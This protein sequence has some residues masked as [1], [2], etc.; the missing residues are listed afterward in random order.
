MSKSNGKN[1]KLLFIIIGVVLAVAIAAGIIF[2]S[3]MGN[4]KTPGKKN[5][6][7][8]NKTPESIELIEEGETVK[9]EDVTAITG[10]TSPDGT[11]VDKEGII[12]QKGHRI[13][14]TGQ[15]DAS[16]NL[17]YTTGKVNSKGQ[18]LYTKNV[19]NSFGELIYY[20]GSYNSDGKLLLKPTSDKPDYTTN[21]RP[22]AVSPTQPS[23]SVT[24]PVTVGNTAK[25]TDSKREAMAFFGGS[26]MDM[27]NSVTSCK[28]GGFVA[29]GYS[30]SYNGSLEGV[31][32]NWAGHGMVVKYDTNGNVLWKYVV[33]GDSEVSFNGV[34]EL[35]DGTIVAVGYTMSETEEPAR[36]SK[37]HSGLIVR[38]KKSGELMWTYVF[39]GG[40]SSSGEFISCVDATPDGGFVVGGKAISS[41]GFFKSDKSG[42][43][44][45]IIKFDK[46]CN[47]KW[48]RVLT[49]SMSN[50]FSAISVN[51][52]GDIYATCETVSTDGDFAGFTYSSELTKNTV[53][54]K[55]NKNGDLE[56][57][58]YLESTG[59]SEYN[60][61]FATEDGGC[62]VGGSFTVKKRTDGIYNMTYGKSDGYVIRYNDKGDVCWARIVGGSGVDYINSVTEY[63]GNVI[64][65]GQTASADLDFA[66]EKL[67]GAED[68]FVMILNEKGNT[69][70][71]MLLD[72]EQ[73]DSATGSCVLEDGS[74]VVS[75]WTKSDDGN[76][77][78]SKTDKN[79]K[80]FV[81]KY[82]PVNE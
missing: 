74:F 76:F 48:R 14:S 59:N 43:K 44:A 75:G 12:D 27:F 80:G 63:E 65:T 60:T 62:V 58:K 68:G 36:T 3:S 18:I 1:K 32:K 6:D 69:T 77:K 45:F 24:V 25:I 41:E 40:M 37:A 46:N 28:D 72:G 23:T 54:V 17:I 70:L 16:G 35:K 49:G 55:L 29:A 67:G 5:N 22:S 50:E 15:K 2:L 71:K 30:S 79:S 66:G 11:V 81:T 21:D 20:T 56:W 42:I 33:G 38:L 47:V 64:V 19:T 78:N 8:V 7:E 52:S 53:L 61:V 31:D 39:P 73:T 57:K 26:G 34:A 13:Y 82:I 9:Q 51:S 4:A 10:A